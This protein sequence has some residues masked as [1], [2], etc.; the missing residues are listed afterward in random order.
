MGHIEI[1]IVKNFAYI[2]QK[3]FLLYTIRREGL[4]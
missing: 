4:L 2:A 3:S 1:E